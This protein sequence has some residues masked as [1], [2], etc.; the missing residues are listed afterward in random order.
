[1]KTWHRATRHR[2]GFSPVELPLVLAILALIG[3]TVGAFLWHH[4]GHMTVGAFIAFGFV[5][6]LVVFVIAILAAIQRD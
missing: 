6:P 4:N 1:M 2:R 3:T 5:L